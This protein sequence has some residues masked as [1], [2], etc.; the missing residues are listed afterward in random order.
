MVAQ[1]IH[2]GLLRDVGDEDVGTGLGRESLQP[3][4][5]SRD[6]DDIPAV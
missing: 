5:A 6:A 1:G 2:V 3:V 4:G